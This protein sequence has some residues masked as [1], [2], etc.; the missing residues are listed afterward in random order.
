MHV[1]PARAALRGRAARRE[2][3]KAAWSRLQAAFKPPPQSPGR[4]P[5]RPAPQY[6]DHGNL[7]FPDRGAPICARP[8]LYDALGVP[9]P[10][11]DAGDARLLQT[12]SGMFAFNRYTGGVQRV[13]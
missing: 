9:N 6:L 12:E 10:H 1:A 8:R 11:D 3:L 5:W 4:R 13:G 2:H 7:F